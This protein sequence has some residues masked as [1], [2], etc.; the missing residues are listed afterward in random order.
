MFARTLWTRN[1]IR[2]ALIVAI[3]L[4]ASLNAF[5]ARAVEVTETP[6][7]AETGTATVE[8]NPEQTQ[9]PATET[10]PAASETPTPAATSTPIAAE[11][12]LP[13]TPVLTQ[14]TLLL[15]IDPDSLAPKST[16]VLTWQIEGLTVEE[17]K[18]LLIQ[19][20]LPD[21][22]SPVGEH[23]G[24]F[25]ETTRTL[26]LPVGDLKGQVEL[27]SGDTVS[28]TVLYAVL[29]DGGAALAE[30]KMPL[31][32]AEQ[33]SL[34]TQGG[35]ITALDGRVTVGFPEDALPEEA[36]IEIGAPSGDGA[37]P[38]SLSGQAFE[39]TAYAETS[40]QEI[41]QFE[42][43]LELSV[44]YADLELLD[45]SE[46][47]LVVYWFDP[48]TQD[49]AGLDSWVDTETKTVHALTDHFTVFDID[50]NNWQATHLPTLN[51]FQVSTF[52]GAATYS[53]PVQVPPGPG[54]LQPSLALSYNSQVV[55]QSTIKTQASWV[56][57]GWDL[58]AGSIELDTHGTPN[59]SSD[60]SYMLN[61]AGVSTHL[62]K[63][64]S[65]VFHTSDENFW[66]I[67]YNSGAETWQIWDKQGNQY[68]FEQS[69]YFPFEVVNSEDCGETQEKTYQWTLTR[70]RNIFGQEIQYNYI[71]D[72]KELNDWYWYSSQA[73]CRFT[74]QWYDVAIYLDT[75]T[76]AGGK[77]RVRFE[78]EN[79][80]D[81]T[82]S[83]ETDVIFHN[84]QRYRLKNIH[85]EQ[86][87]NSDGVFETIRRYQFSYAA[88]SDADI[89]FPGYTWSKGGKALT[90]RSVQEYGVG[91]TTSL[92]ATT[93][94]YDNMHL[95][96]AANGYGG[97][98]QFDYELYYYSADAR[99]SYT[100]YDRVGLGQTT[101]QGGATYWPSGS[102]AGS[103]KWDP[104][105]PPIDYEDC[106]DGEL[107]IRGTVLGTGFV[108]DE[109]LRP[110]GVYK[111]A[112]TMWTGSVNLGIYDG[113]ADQM[114]DGNGIVILPKN[115]WKLQAL[116]KTTSTVYMQVATVKLQLLPMVYRVQTRH[117]FDGKGNEYLYTYTY[118]NPA[119]NDTAHS[120]S[121]CPA[122]F[123]NPPDANCNEYVEQFSEF[124]GHGLVTETGP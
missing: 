64:A 68:F 21:V 40:G 94:T 44:S 43:E 26:S 46:K 33:F 103:S 20:I 100:R 62:V 6:T 97:R 95:V 9:P 55:D 3:L 115:A 75:I 30:T 41:E 104:R 116:M 109:L 82:A 31:S 111:L 76:Y 99:H 114:A 80:T 15:S 45:V 25:D 37:P 121:A 52:T 110:G 91:G 84:Y 90:L 48:E 36:V 86:D 56:G 93:F 118:T 29:L 22:L 112:A 61:A 12:I 59:T 10:P 53:L 38:S 24:I 57:M 98:V 69:S 35:E 122:T 87:A 65:G 117:L 8:P 72:Q 18:E 4:S 92:P 34:D 77:Y 107:T 74:K 102:C 105:T 50:A 49:W 2:I 23:G 70:Q 119:V 28:E 42:K 1:V 39:I 81:Y 47:D 63:D 96:E 124:R 108:G 85:V 11:T 101:W 13:E 79:R 54:G 5:S 32:P 19:I 14:P 123:L 78:R 106:D 7:A 27:A 67:Q 120:A 58:D 113:N 51:P 89:I 60:D 17:H 16:Y 73:E 71:R 66:K 83:W 88:N